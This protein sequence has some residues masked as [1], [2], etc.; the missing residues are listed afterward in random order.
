MK[1]L[2]VVL[3]SMILG[4]FLSLFMISKRTQAAIE[5]DLSN[6]KKPKWL[7]LFKI[8]PDDI[9]KYRTIKVDVRD[10]TKIIKEKQSEEGAD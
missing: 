5:I 4:A 10:V 3:I 8:S 6:P 9:L 7:F 1:T 2:I